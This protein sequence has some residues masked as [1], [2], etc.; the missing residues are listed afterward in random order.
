[1]HTYCNCLARENGS[2][3]RQVG[4]V[5]RKLVPDIM[6]GKM[7]IWQTPQCRENGYYQ[8]AEFAMDCDQFVEEVAIVLQLLQTRKARDG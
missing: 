1:M 7:V 8:V 3:K 6:N 4:S 2:V 5:P